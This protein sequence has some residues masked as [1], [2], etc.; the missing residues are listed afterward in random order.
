MRNS[1]LSAADGMQWPI[2]IPYYVQRT[3][4]RVQLE[5]LIAKANI[6]AIS[7][8]RIVLAAQA[9]GFRT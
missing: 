8:R 4:L 6:Q 1:C 3:G 5:P 7:A 2:D 9:P